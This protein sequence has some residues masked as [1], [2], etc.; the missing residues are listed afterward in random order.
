M[1]K[2]NT[3]IGMLL[4]I[5]AMASFY[6]SAKFAPPPPKPAVSTPPSS[7]PIA[8]NQAPLPGPARTRADAALVAGPKASGTREFTTLANDHIEVKFT[9]YGGAIESV[10]L[11]KHRAELGRPDPYVLNH[12][13]EAGP[14]LALTGYPGLDQSAA[15]ELVS[16][17][18]TEVVYRTVVDNRMEVTR[19]FQLIAAAASTG[20]PYQIR[21]ETSI[22]NLTDQVLPLGRLG[23]SLG[24]AAPLNP[25]DSGLYL[26]ASYSDGKG[27]STIRRG[28]L[29][30]GGFF[31]PRAPLPFIEKPSPLAWAAVNN[32]FFTAIL[33][34]D[35]PG[36]GIHVERVKLDHALPNE[37]PSAYG[38]SG[39]AQFELK[40]IPAD[41]SVTLGASYYAGPKEYR[42]LANSDYFKQSEDLVMQFGFFGFFSKLLLTIMT[43]VHSWVPSWGWAV[44]ITTLILK[45]VFV[46]FTIAASRSSKRMQR[47]MPAIQ[48][49]REKFKDDP[50]KVNEGMMRLYKE[51]KVNPLGG[52]IPVLI[53]IPF[54]IG[55]FSM[56][57]SASEL[58][59]APFLW[60]HDL[61]A[62]DTVLSFGA[63]TLPLLGLTHLNLNVM[64]LLMGAT[65]IIQMR[66]TPTPTTDG[67][68]ATMFK[69][70]PWIFIAICYN[71][72]CAL[73]LY[74]T[75]NGLFTIGQQLV[76]N[77]MPEPD[78]PT[79]PGEPKNVTP[80]RKRAR[81]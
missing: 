34:L 69:L 32:Q 30:G 19:R 60:A 61:S 26:N 36:V 64:P 65:T 10:A 66:L 74:S 29:E 9:N 7:S 38:L 50:R 8:R 45:I 37:N 31:G 73:A 15:Y 27:A 75:I 70:M 2:K 16:R 67:A 1:D 78:L 56:L 40:P 35:E 46:P 28:A 5:A 81:K 55:F 22:R 41:A 68:Q 24:T 33:T 39:F 57:Q 4:L 51:N 3:A 58:R 25:T 71:F 11:K 23:L 43:W 20:D 77:R 54:F 14:A 47:L 49:L 18:D 62:P 63:I 42:R 13:E 76:I 48:A 12:A 21:T 52:C 79:L 53:T 59:F 44:V 72:S 17:T 6:F 80:Q